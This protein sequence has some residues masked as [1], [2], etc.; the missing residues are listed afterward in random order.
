[1][2]FQGG[3]PLNPLTDGPAGTAGARITEVLL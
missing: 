2:T 1:M 3:H